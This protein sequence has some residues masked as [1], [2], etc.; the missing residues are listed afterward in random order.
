MANVNL[1]VG[2]CINSAFEM[3]KKH[4]LLLAL[5]FVAQSLV[6]YFLQTIFSFGNSMSQS[7]IME[8][9]QRLGERMGQGD[10]EAIT[11][12]LQLLGQTSNPIGSF[13]SS[14]ISF[15][16]TIFI[17]NLT[18]GLV[19]GRFQSFTLDAFKMPVMTYV[20]FFVVS[21]LCGI[22]IGLGLVLCLIPGIYLGCRL[23]Y[24]PYVVIDEPDTDV[25]AAIKKSWAMTADNVFP[26]F[27]LSLAFIGLAFVGLLCCCVGMFYASA[28]TALATAISFYVLKPNAEL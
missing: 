1:S 5:V 10:T 27:L 18:L 7:D 14:I 17:A 9:G 28:I 23:M 3:S 19:S 12:Y 15:V 6:S 4:G 22:I 24:A 11:E 13:L 20:K 8:Q 16:F 26:V 21:L 2:E 25:M